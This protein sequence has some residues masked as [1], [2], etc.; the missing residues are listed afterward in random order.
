MKPLHLKATIFMAF[1]LIMNVNGLKRGVKESSTW[2]FK[3]WIRTKHRLNLKRQ[4][5]CLP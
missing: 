5:L 1:I 2:D 3:W 4:A